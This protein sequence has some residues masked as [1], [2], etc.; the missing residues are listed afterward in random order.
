MLQN[1]SG[2]PLKLLLEVRV[3]SLLQYLPVSPQ[4]SLKA[5]TLDIVT[6]SSSL[7]IS[8]HCKIDTRPRMALSKC[9]TLTL[10]F[11]VSQEVG[12]STTCFFKGV[13]LIKTASWG[14]GGFKASW[15][16]EEWQE[17]RC[18]QN[19][20]ITTCYLTGIKLSL[21]DGGGLANVH[22]KHQAGGQRA[23]GEDWG[24]CPFEIFGWI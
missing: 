8:L 23:A 24:L 16:E 4:H 15:L 9:C 18:F 19:K 10:M 21:P 6:N 22:H 1:F 7:F 17:C 5:L 13:F 11:A 2:A 20:L 14:V 3:C 12:D